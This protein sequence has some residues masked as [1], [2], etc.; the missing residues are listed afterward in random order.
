MPP[1]V[2]RR[3]SIYGSDLNDTL[4]AP[5]SPPTFVLGYDIY[6]YA[7]N[8]ILNSY[9]KND[10][11]Y[12]GTGNDQL[13]GGTGS[14]YLEGGEGNDLYYVEA[15]GNTIIEASGPNSGRDLVRSEIDFTLPANVEMLE[16]LRGAIR[17]IGNTEIN[18]ITGNGNNNYIDGGRGADEMFGGYGND[19][20]LIDNLNDKIFDEGDYDKVF[21][22]VTYNANVNNI[23]F[24]R[25]WTIEEF[26][27]TTAA[28]L[29]YQDTDRACIISGN[30]GKNTIEGY[31]GADTIY[32]KDGN[33]T[34]NGGVGADI[35]WGG[36][37]SD[38]FVYTGTRVSLGAGVD[39]IMDFSCMED[40]IDLSAI[41]ADSLNV[42]NQSFRYVGGGQFT[43]YT[44]MLK[45]SN[46]ILSGDINGD[47]V[48]DFQIEVNVVGGAMSSNCIIL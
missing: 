34:I 30:S 32:G 29:N 22:S 35:L 25:D 15:L 42:G 47:K 28:D 7:G 8:D 12:G 10:N 1:F 19:T 36:A 38:T 11:L 41:D 24:G 3:I 43:G 23:R 27:L 33:D 44:G 6:G 14:N 26:T 45:F 4:Y 46:G 13:Y 39:R 20:Y 40:K 9:S 21:S 17:G 16:L 48:A 2:S 5:T 31:G 18:Y 37:G